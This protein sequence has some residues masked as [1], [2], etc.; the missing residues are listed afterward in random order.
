MK[1]GEIELK[2]LQRGVIA[3]TGDDLALAVREGRVD[4]GIATR[5]TA[6]TRGLIF[7]RWSGR[8]SIL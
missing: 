7:F 3:R 6:A 5:A 4:C 1:L 2:H 8:N